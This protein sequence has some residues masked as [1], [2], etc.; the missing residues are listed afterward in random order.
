MSDI[1]PDL[2]TLAQPIDSLELLDGNPRIGD[3][4]AVAAS[5][6]R[7]GQRKPIVARRSDRQIIA[8]NHT[9]KAACQLGWAEIAVVLV[10]D[11]DATAKAFALADNRTAELGG[12]DDANLAAMIAEVGEFDAALLADTGWSCEAVDRLLEEIAASDQAATTDDDTVDDEVVDPPAPPA[13][14]VTKRGDVWLLGPHRILCGDC[15]EPDDVARLLNGAAV[16]VAFTSPPYASQRTY[17]ESSGFKPIRPDEY[18]EW[19]APVSANVAEHLS[20]DGSWFVNIKAN[21]ENGQRHLYVMDLVL[22]H[23]RQWEWLVVDEFCWMRPSPPG[24]WP[25]RFKNGFEPVFHFTT[26]QRIKFRP[27]SVAIDS[28]DVPVPSS[29]AG[30]NTSGPNGEYWNLSMQTQHGKAWPSNVLKVSGVEPGTGHSAAFPVGLPEWFIKAYSDPGDN[31][32]DP[33][34]GSGSTL[35]AAHKQDRVAYGTE[36]SPAYVDVICARFQRTTGIA[37]VLE[38]T[39]EAHDFTDT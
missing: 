13:D 16:N 6:R 10:D 35:I 3:V 23:A 34:M 31:V 1:A 22:A 28:D 7:F 17:D 14:P 37:P 38:A 18:V 24:R 30:A 8:G 39:G 36:L 26:G 21:A 12:Y 33:F 2:L 25:N 4:D 20:E 19:F 11:D 29:V 27:E 9:Y 32:F 15:R 5:L